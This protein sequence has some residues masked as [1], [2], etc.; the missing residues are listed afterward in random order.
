MRSAARPAPPTTGWLRPSR[1]PAESRRGAK[2]TRTRPTKPTRRSGQPRRWARSRS[3]SGAARTP[4]G[5][6]SG[7]RSRAGDSY[8]VG[9][10]A[11]LLL[12]DGRA[13][14][15]AD[16]VRDRTENEVLLRLVLA[17]VASPAKQAEP[18]A[19]LLASRS[20]AS[21]L[22]GEP[23][24]AGKKR[25]SFCRCATM[26][27]PRLPSAGRLERQREPWD[28]KS[29]SSPRWRPV[30]PRPLPRRSRS[31]GST[32]CRTLESTRWS[33]SSPR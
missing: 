10:F 17:E 29:C 3:G 12:D 5:M 22:R 23:S 20:D 27:R 33:R 19:A 13:R 31:F 15:A 7:T 16:L 1:S 26:R 14:A 21:H 28:V 6:S 8:V 32:D 4:A 2:E 25:V 11:D 30:R 24:T 18:H 9:A